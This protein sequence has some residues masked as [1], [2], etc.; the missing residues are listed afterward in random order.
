MS[1][2]KKAKTK[3]VKESVVKNPIVAEENEKKIVGIV[4]SVQTNIKSSKEISDSEIVNFT[5]DLIMA[6]ITIKGI[7]VQ[8]RLA[9]LGDYMPIDKTKNSYAI[10]KFLLSI[11][12][13]K[14][15]K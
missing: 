7:K 11:Y 10:A 12:D 15:K 14:R 2:I 1:K 4:E 5:K 9:T 8:G 3:A 6:N 13:I